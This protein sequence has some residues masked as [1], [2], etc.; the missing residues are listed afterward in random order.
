MPIPRFT[1]NRDD[2]MDRH[3]NGR[4]TLYSTTKR[5]MDERDLL[6]KK[7]RAVESVTDSVTP[8]PPTDA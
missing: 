1:P 3:K 5:I 6:V 7:L 2:G 4:Y 8:K